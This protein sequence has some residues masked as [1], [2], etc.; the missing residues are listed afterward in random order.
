M[1]YAS[2]S[3]FAIKAIFATSVMVPVVGQ[4]ESR[5]DGHS[6]S[7]WMAG[8][9][10]YQRYARSPW[11]TGHGVHRPGHV[12]PATQWGSGFSFQRPYPYHLDYYRMRYGGSYE[13]YHGFLYGT[14][15]VYAPYYGQTGPLWNPHGY[16]DPVFPPQPMPEPL[17]QQ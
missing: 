5:R 8:D 14:P 3:N 7:P 1:H 16:A 4:A 12:F 9:G 13:P 11:A 10:V 15:K 17:P 6:Q 2:L